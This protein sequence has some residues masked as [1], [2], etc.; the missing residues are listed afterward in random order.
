MKRVLITGASG[1]IGRHALQFLSGR[2]FDVHAVSHRRT[3]ENAAVSWHRA[4]LLDPFQT[5][6]LLAAVRPTHLLHF[7]WYTMPR[8]YRESDEN[9]RWCQAGI[10]LVKCF[11][12]S[13]GQR[14]VFA[15]TCFEYDL[16][17]GFCS[18]DLTPSSPSTLYGTCK[19]SLREVV[20]AFGSRA[21]LSTAWGRI[22]Y[23]YGPHEAPE[24]LVPAVIRE[25]LEKKR[26][27]CTH[28]RQVRDFLHVA[29]LA[30]AFVAL[31]DSEIQGV[32]NIGSGEPVTVRTIASAIAKLIGGATEVELGAIEAAPG[33]PPMVV[34]D[35]GRLRDR[36]GW[37]P[38][39]ALE[40]GLCDSIRFWRESLSAQ[41]EK[42]SRICRGLE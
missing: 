24:R 19:N 30:E 28:G 11:A 17:Y 14:A 31:L 8:D 27:R 6:E 33:D 21:G 18:E 2:G 36:V 15:G 22:F 37:T 4:D 12:G 3:V 1:F 41:D 40:R 25:L 5:R 42:L 23:V 9:L 35:I 26:A 38:R 34:A 20:S 7:A 39:W 32:V 13:G 29:D 16:R 10:E